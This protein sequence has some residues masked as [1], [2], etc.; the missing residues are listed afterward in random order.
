VVALFEG[1]S[2]SPA[3]LSGQGEPAPE[4]VSVAGVYDRY[5]DF[6][7]CALRRLGVQPRQLEDAVQDVFVVVQRRLADFE[8]RSSLKTWLF[9]IALRVA[10]DHR[11]RQVKQA[12]EMGAEDDSLVGT[13][14]DPREAALQ[15]EAAALVQT[16]LDGLAEERRVVFVLTEL[17]EFSAAEIAETLGI[18]INS[19]YTRLRLARRDFNQALKRH[20]AR[21]TGKAH[22]QP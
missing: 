4:F 21:P 15:A 16:L 19:V 13:H 8:G 6:V 18:G 7:W 3:P 22:E 9:G 17:E 10:K 11:R 2:S 20:H 14:P 1:G 12:V 5:F